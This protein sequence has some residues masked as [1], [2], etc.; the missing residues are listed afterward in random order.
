MLKCCFSALNTC[1]SHNSPS[2][3]LKIISELFVEI[4]VRVAERKRWFKTESN[5]FQLNLVS[6]ILLILHMVIY[7]YSWL[8]SGRFLRLGYQ[9]KMYAGLLSCLLSLYGSYHVR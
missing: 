5:P 3:F 6:R 2:E 4:L 1:S 9:Q 8:F 7:A